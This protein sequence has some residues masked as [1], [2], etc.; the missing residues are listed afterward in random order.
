MNT[1]KEEYLIS[2]NETLKEEIQELEQVVK[3]L[4]SIA[5]DFAPVHKCPECDRYIKVGYVCMHCGYNEE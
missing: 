5:E 3:D 1:P 4:L 2:E